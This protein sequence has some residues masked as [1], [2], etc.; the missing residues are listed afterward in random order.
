[1]F[2]AVWRFNNFSYAL[3]IPNITG[4]RITDMH[5]RIYKC[6]SHNTSSCIDLFANFDFIFSNFDYF[7]IFN[8]YICLNGFHVFP[9]QYFGVFN[10]YHV[11]QDLF[12]YKN[13]L[14]K[15][16]IL[17]YFIILRFKYKNLNH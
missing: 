8:Y 2:K 15:N 9:M 7:I 1:M 13:I 12:F 11:N 14:S 10:C 16:I 5:M 4:Y 17:N 6:R 3:S